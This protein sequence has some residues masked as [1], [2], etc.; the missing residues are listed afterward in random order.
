MLYEVITVAIVL[1]GVETQAQV[2]R[3][4]ARGRHWIA[5]GWYYA[6][7]MRS[8]ELAGYIAQH[9]VAEGVTRASVVCG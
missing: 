2:E 3:L 8:A 1:E 5:Q 9:G 6:K 4:T 7:A